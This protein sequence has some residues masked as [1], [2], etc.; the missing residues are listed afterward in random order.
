MAIIPT[1]EWKGNA[2]R[3]IDQ[4]ILPGKF[5]VITC[6]DVKTLWHAIKTLQVR[7]A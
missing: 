4:T 3:L 5:K 6:R 2:C 7:G 1:I